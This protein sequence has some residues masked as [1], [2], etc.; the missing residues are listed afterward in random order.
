M[1]PV[2]E[3]EVTFVAPRATKKG[4]RL[5]GADAT[6]SPSG[7][8]IVTYPAGGFPIAHTAFTRFSDGFVLGGL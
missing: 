2:V 3:S 5:A 8:I 6:W 7:V 4:M 1:D